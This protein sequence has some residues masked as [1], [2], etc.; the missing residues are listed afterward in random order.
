MLEQWLIWADR[1]P[2]AF[3]HFEVADVTQTAP[4]SDAVQTHIAELIR[5]SAIDLSFLEDVTRRLGW[6]KAESLVRQRL[7]ENLSARRGRFGE[8]IGVFMLHQ[9]KGYVVPIEK[10]HFAITGGQSQPST[11]AVLLKVEDGKVREVCFVESKLRTGADN[12]AAV[13]GARQLLSDYQKETPDMLWFTAARLFERRDPLYEPFMAYLA[14]RED[15]REKD[16]FR[17]LLFYDLLAWSEKS[18][19]NLTD[20]EPTLRPLHVLVTR[21]D[22]LKEL[23]QQIFERVGM[24]VVDDEP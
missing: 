18:L 21:L 2:R 12:F 16:T 7:P 14:S 5:T 4:P 15:M 23:V 9:L 11:D 8:V 20:E 10:A 6:Q 24:T 13:E 1:D 22:G 19:S 17:L 3:S